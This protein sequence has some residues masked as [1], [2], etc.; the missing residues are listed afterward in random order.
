MLNTVK[1]QTLSALGN[2]SLNFEKLVILLCLTIR[3]H[4]S[5]A[6]EV[7]GCFSAKSSS[8]FRV[9]M[10]MQPIVS[11][12]EI[13]RKYGYV[14]GLIVFLH[15]A[16]NHRQAKWSVFLCNNRAIASAQKGA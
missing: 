4:A 10:C 7:F 9:I 11:R 13:F 5:R 6:V 12:I 15:N 3:Y 2:I 1:L 8:R 16:A 14:V